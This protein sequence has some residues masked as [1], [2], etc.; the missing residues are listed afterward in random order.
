MKNKI[1][2]LS[3]LL[4][5]L[6]GCA[7]KSAGYGDASNFMGL[8][9]IAKKTVVLA[10][11]GPAKPFSE[12]GVVALDSR[13]RLRSLRTQSEDDVDTRYFAKGGL[14]IINTPNDVQIHLE[15][16]SYIASFCFWID[17]GNQGA[18]YCQADQNARFEVKAGEIQQF[19]WAEG[20][21]GGGWTILKHPATAEAQARVV[22]DFGQVMNSV[23][24]D[25]QANQ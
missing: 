20:Q 2:C 13:L 9:F 25:A 7:I 18:I 11:D 8:G 4:L 23:K 24:E 21:K 16:G 6:T 10:Y 14:G 1:L 15:P 19:S 17:R 12:V 22:K 3:I 5:A